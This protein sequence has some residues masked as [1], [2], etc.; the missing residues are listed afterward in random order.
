MTPRVP[1]SVLAL[2]LVMY[3]NALR[4]QEPGVMRA[5]R[6]ICFRARMLPRCRAFWLTE[7][8]LATRLGGHSTP[9]GLLSWEL[10]AMRNVGSRTALGG[11]LY[12]GIPTTGSGELEGVGV[13]PRFRRWLG[14][15]VALDVSPGILFAGNGSPGFAGHVGLTMSHWL[16]LT[17]QAQT[18]RPT[19]GSRRTLAWF[20][21]AKLGGLPGAISG[22]ATLLLGLAFGVA[23]SGS[24]GCGG[25]N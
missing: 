25:G 5:P 6:S 15:G 7:F 1:G 19:V 23:C 10:G 8:G 20:G 24:G 17:V 3:A 2:S 11:S 13:K 21:G 18:V 4:S 22:G 14:P 16:A 9:D 12:L